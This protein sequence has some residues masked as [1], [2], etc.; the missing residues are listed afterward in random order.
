[1]Q[2]C[3]IVL[4]GALELVDRQGTIKGRSIMKACFVLHCIVDC[5]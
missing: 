4:L 5:K 3:G 2:K 1:M